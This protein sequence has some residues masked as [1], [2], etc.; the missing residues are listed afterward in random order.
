MFDEVWVARLAVNTAHQLW[1]ASGDPIGA[2]RH[3]AYM[4]AKEALEQAKA[5]A[6]EPEPPPVAPEFPRCCNIGVVSFEG[7]HSH[8]VTCLVHGE[9]HFGTKD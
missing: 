9:V 4:A 6:R 7:W 5:L 2:P 3:V 8:T 1:V